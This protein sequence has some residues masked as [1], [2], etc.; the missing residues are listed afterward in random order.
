MVERPEAM[1]AAFTEAGAA[2]ILV[3]PESTPHIRRAIDL[4]LEAGVSAG[5]SLNPGTPLSA[6]D[7]LF[8]HIEEVLLMTVNPGWGGQKLIVDQ[9]HKVRELR[10]RIDSEQA[11]PMD[12]GVDGGISPATA[13]AAREAGANV[14]VVGTA[15]FSADDRSLAVRVMLGE[16]HLPSE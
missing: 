4:I 5:I 16:A 13:W 6:A 8:L 9:L 10:R 3:H 12:V 1:I 7:E 2:R 14:L 15:L 11:P